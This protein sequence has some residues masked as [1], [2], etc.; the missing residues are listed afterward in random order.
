MSK[1]VNYTPEQTTELV[2]AYVANP[3]KETVAAFAEKF[4]KNVRSITMKLTREG[5]YKK[6]EYTTKTGEKVQ[7]KNELADAIGAVLQLT[8]PDI[9]SLTKANKS[10]LKAI[11]SALANSK[12]IET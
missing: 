11:F 3:T 10:A 12:P 9:E 4:G 1:V 7:P 2:S 6:A 5:V 8:E